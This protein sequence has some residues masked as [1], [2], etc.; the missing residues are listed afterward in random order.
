MSSL[1]YNLCASDL[2]IV[3][4]KLAKQK[5][6]LQEF[7]IDIFD[8]PFNLLDSSMS[9][10]V[11]PK[12]YFA[13]VN[14]RVNSLFKY[15]DMLNLYPVFLTVTCPPRF[16]SNSNSY[17][18]S[19]VKESVKYLSTRWASFL[20]LK[21]F[22]N[23]KN[24]VN[25]NMIYI[26]VLEPH[27]DGTPH[28]HVL[29]FIPKNFILPV[30]KVFKRHF[31]SDGA[32]RNANNEAFKYTWS[33]HAGGAIAYILK[34]INKTFKH[35]LDDK[36][37]LEAYYY[38]FHSIRRF[39]TSQTLLPLYVHRRIKHNEKF[40]DFIWSTLKYKDG[41]IY[42]IF[43]KKV[44][45]YRYMTEDDGLQEDVIYSRSPV[46]DELF[47]KKITHTPKSI[48]AF[49]DTPKPLIYINDRLTDYVFN[50]NRFF[51]AKKPFE[52]YSNYS[53]LEYYNNLDV[54]HCDINHLIHIRNICVSRGLIDSDPILKDQLFGFNDYKNLITFD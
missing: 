24:A 27:K 21:I 18:G 19:S 1:K 44:F 30:K 10:N 40:R 51:V 3:D 23:I 20:R 37:T 47:P 14:N 28:C 31:S 4:N 12:K 53:I 26:R 41:T 36:M 50:H 45:L 7:V 8:E 2:K 52:K 39:T 11:N 38:A 13:E 54:D 25:H 33:G 42:H 46:L 35:A 9:A 17:D 34:Y 29:M 5:K 16:H 22:K 49:R 43:D 32:T 6:F 48:K 15:A